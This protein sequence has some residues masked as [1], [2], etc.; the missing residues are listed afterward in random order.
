ITIDI[1][2]PKQ[3]GIPGY[4]LALERICAEVS[5]AIQQGFKV[6]VLSDIATNAERVAISSL[7]AIGGVHH[8]LVRSKQRSKI[9]LISESAEAR[10]VHHICVLLGY[11][12]D[13]IC[14]YLAMEAVLKLKRENV[15][16]SDLSPEKFI[17][18]YK[19]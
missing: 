7:I 9:A 10:E 19:K 13:A 15:I 14:P 17:S 12:A 18:N 16:K 1:T 6:V 8:H 3:E 5:L 4:L 2:F 11:G